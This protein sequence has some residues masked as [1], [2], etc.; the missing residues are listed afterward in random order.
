MRGVTLTLLVFLTSWVLLLVQPATMIHQPRRGLASVSRGGHFRAHRKSLSLRDSDRLILMFDGCSRGNPGP[1][2]AGAVLLQEKEG[3]E[4]TELWSGFRF[5]GDRVT[6]NQAEYAGLKLGLLGVLRNTYPDERSTLVVQGDS[7]FVVRQL[8]G[9]Y[10]VKS[11]NISG[12]H[13]EV[14]SLLQGLQSRPVFEHIP[15]SLNF[16]ADELS[17][18]AVDASNI[19]KISNSTSSNSSNSTGKSSK[20][21]AATAARAR[22]LNLNNIT[23]HIFLCADQSKPLCCSKECGLESWQFLKQRCKELEIPGFA[24]SKVNCLQVCVAG[25]IAVVYGGESRGVWYHSCTPAVLERIL[26]EHV[27]KGNIVKEYQFAGLVKEEEE[28]DV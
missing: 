27:L 2:G 9:K 18:L 24:R 11:P 26:Q 13:K 8:Q 22:A 3:G 21:A 14:T 20:V 15:R 25:P 4:R 10:K 12:L 5:L 6:N 17:N 7:E 16:R 23:R 19:E 1:G 28:E